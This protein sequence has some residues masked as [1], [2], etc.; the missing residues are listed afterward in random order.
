MQQTHV[1]VALLGVTLDAKDNVH[2]AVQPHTVRTCATACSNG[3]D[4]GCSAVQFLD[5]ICL[6]KILRS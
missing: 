2:A 6:G 4:V 5:A 1:H 3:P